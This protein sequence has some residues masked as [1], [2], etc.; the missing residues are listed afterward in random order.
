[1]KCLVVPLGDIVTILCGLLPAFI[2]EGEGG[3]NFYLEVSEYENQNILQPS[4]QLPPLL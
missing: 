3:A 2:V 4:S 1:M